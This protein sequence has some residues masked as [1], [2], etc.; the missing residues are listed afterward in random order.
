MLQQLVRQL[1]VYEVTKQELMKR[2][3]LLM[4]NMKPIIMKYDAIPFL[5]A[6]STKRATIST[7]FLTSFP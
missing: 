6:S 4:R 5:A 1:A 3:L 7:S 2:V